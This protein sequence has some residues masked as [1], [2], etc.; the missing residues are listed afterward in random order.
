MVFFH[1]CFMLINCF[2]FSTE[3]NSESSSELE[4]SDSPAKTWL[5]V[6]SKLHHSSNTC[7]GCY[8]IRDR[9]ISCGS[10]HRQRTGTYNLNMQNVFK[11]NIFS[12]VHGIWILYTIF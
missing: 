8:R 2:P 3:E 5:N 10:Y 6:S 7:L 4:E 9:K 1:L 11:I 12:P